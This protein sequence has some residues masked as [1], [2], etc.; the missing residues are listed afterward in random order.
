MSWR[1]LLN[2]ALALLFLMAGVMAFSRLAAMR[3]A[4]DRAIHPAPVTVVRTVVLERGP[5]RESLSGYGRAR[6]LRRTVVSSRV[7]GVV[8][9]ISPQL[10]AGT[11]VEA[12]AELVRLERRDLEQA[13]ERAESDLGRSIAV[14]AQHVVEEEGLKLRLAVSKAEL[15]TSQDELARSE[16]LAGDDTISARERDAQRRATNL[17]E[18]QTM[19]LETRR[20]GMTPMLEADEAVVRW[21]RT[22]VDQARTDLAR[23]TIAAPYQGRVEERLAELGARVVPGTDLFRVVDASRVELA[24]QLPASRFGDVVAGARAH[25]RLTD[26]GPVAWEGCVARVGAVVDEQDSTFAAYLVIEHDPERPAVPPGAFALATVDGRRHDDVIPIPRIAFLGDLIYVAE[27]GSAADPGQT[28]EDGARPVSFVA[29]SRRP[30]IVRE[31]PDVA[32]ATSGVAAGDLV[33]VS[34]LERLGEGSR[35]TVR[36]LDAVPAGDD[37]NGGTHRGSSR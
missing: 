27:P 11:L 19:D 2:G 31:L 22:V 3:E 5:F 29:R 12:G 4:P 16:A 34:N 25:V 23:T 37:A 26:V 8:E 21:N 17:L 30:V 36:D 14:R 13:L 20:L 18:R 10:E 35:V 15:E 9:W 24:I 1:L 33:I 28:D 7:D 32:L 6:A